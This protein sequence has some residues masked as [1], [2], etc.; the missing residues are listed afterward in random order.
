LLSKIAQLVLEKKPQHFHP[1]NL[2]RFPSPPPGQVYTPPAPKVAKYQIFW[3]CVRLFARPENTKNEATP[4][5]SQNHKK[6]IFVHQGFN[7]H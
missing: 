2:L 6:T 7:F 4:K 5:T 3:I 1:H